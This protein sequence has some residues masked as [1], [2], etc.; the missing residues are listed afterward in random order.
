MSIWANANLDYKI[1]SFC[2]SAD[3]YCGPYFLRQNE[4]W[5]KG[6]NIS[7]EHITFV[8]GV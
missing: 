2:G 7:K 6:T 5:L 4:V 8:F 1:W 3:S